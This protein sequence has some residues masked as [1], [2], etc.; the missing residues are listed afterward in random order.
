MDGSFSCGSGLGAVR[1]RSKL[2]RFGA[3]GRYALGLPFPWRNL[4]DRELAMD[5][6]VLVASNATT[7]LVERDIRENKGRKTSI[8]SP[9]CEPEVIVGFANP[10]CFMCAK[11][12]SHKESKP[13]GPPILTSLNIHELRLDLTWSTRA[14]I[15]HRVGKLPS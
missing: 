1:R 4:T 7:P 14:I 11:T 5:G 2:S 13:A 6:F 15:N 3:A 10:Q 12:D 9:T 8:Y